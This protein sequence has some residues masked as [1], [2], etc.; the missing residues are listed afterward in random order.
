M[1]KSLSK[2]LSGKMTMIFVFLTIF[3]AVLIGVVADRK[4]DTLF[5]SSVYQTQQ[6]QT[7]Q[8][9][10]RLDQ[11]LEDGKVSI[12][13]LANSPYVRQLGSEEQRQ[14][15]QSFYENNGNFELIFCVNAEGKI[16]NTWP[17][18]DFGGKSDFT[19][20]QWFKDVTRAN[21]VLLSDTYVSAFTQQATAPIVAPV[22]D[23]TGRIL[24][25]MGGNIKLDN[26]SKL[27]KILDSGATGRGV[28]LDK[29]HF[30]LTDSRD[31]E[32]GK[33]HEAFTDDQILSAVQDGA[34][35]TIAVGQS[36]ISYSPIGSTGWAVLKSQSTQEAMASTEDLQELI[37]GVIAASAL[38][39]G[40]FVFYYVRRICQPVIAV[41]HAA[42]EIA[43]GHIVQTEIVYHGN[44][45]LARLIAA[46]RKMTDNL[47]SL[48][49][50]TRHS[51]VM[52]D[53]ATSQFVAASHQ[54]AQAAT[55]ISQEISEVTAGSDK[56]L[57]TV[58]KAVAL[59]KEISAQIGEI[60]AHINTVISVSGQAASKADEGN[61]EIES[62][63]KQMKATDMT[64]QDLSQKISLLGK[65][66]QQI[67]QII[68]T[69]SSIAGQ[70]NL[71][72]LNAAIEAARAGEQG[73]GFAVVAE[74][75]RQLAAQSEGAA[76]QITELIRNIQQDTA[77]AV[78][79]MEDGTQQ[80][81]LGSG[82][83]DK[84]GQ[85]FYAITT[86]IHSASEKISIV[87]E[88]VDQM[89]EKDSQI[90]N[91]IQE[92]AVVSK[93][94]AVHTQSVLASTEEQTAAME[95]IASSS[96]SLDELVNDLNRLM[97]K[98]QL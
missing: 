46:F 36:L 78:C 79:A 77:N 92:I 16:T 88:A 35:K 21:K 58:Q 96:Q 97:N 66:S 53:S 83:V 40:L 73:H 31:E 55:Q 44:D 30:Y 56:Q 38:V 7:R 2:S 27:A 34:E 10:N 62:V 28:I 50:Q 49:K 33:K 32:K 5:K 20:R 65:Q 82:M 87:S 23:E 8:I 51:A 26:V 81:R 42:E 67:E 80:I 18:T 48:V 85:T 90:V 91:A 19:D 86:L 54:S 47:H 69:I 45:E 63:I 9:S 94:N 39:I 61:Q 4:A 3:P 89:E 68:Q 84:T 25:Y 75:V 57:D 14:A 71:L 76:K 93:E 72:A 17:H 98:F 24:G 13:T 15:M 74:E 95:E 1:I 43:G 60:V 22:V 59:G 37:I 52:V 11:Y 70:T 29:Q 6:G 41:A 64:M 12:R